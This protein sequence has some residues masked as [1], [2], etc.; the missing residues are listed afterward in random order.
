MHSENEQGASSEKSKKLMVTKKTN[1]FDLQYPG[2][3]SENEILRNKDGI[4]PIVLKQDRVWL[5]PQNSH[6]EN[7][8]NLIVFGDNLQFLKTVYENKDALIKDRI[9]GRVKLIYID[10]PFATGEHYRANQGQTAYS[11]KRVGAD[12]IEFLRR[13]LI[14]AREIL[15]DDGVIVVRN[16]YNYGHYVKIILDEIFSLEN[17]INE[18]IINRKRK[19]MGSLK[20][21][22]VA[23]EYLYAY[24]KS[25]RYFFENQWAKKPLSKIKW[26]SFLSQ[27]ERNPP[28]RQVLGLTFLPPAGQH[29]SLNQQ[30]TTRL[31]KEHY[32][33]V[34]HKP[35]GAIFYYSE[36]G[37]DDRFYKVIST[38]GVNKFKYQDITNETEVYGVRD[39]REIG[40]FRQAPVDEF[41]IEY[42]TREEEKITSDWRDIPSYTDTTGYPTENSEPLLA[43]IIKSFTQP[44]DLVLDFFA[45]SGTTAIVAE[46]LNRRWIAVDMGKLAYS[47]IQKRLLQIQHSKNLE[48]K[49]KTHAKCASTFLT[50]ATHPGQILKNHE[51]SQYKKLISTVF[52]LKEADGEFSEVAFDGYLADRPVLIPEFQQLTIEAI[53]LTYLAKLARQINPAHDLQVYVIA[54]Q[55]AFAFQQDLLRIDRI[56]FYFLR[57]PDTIL[58]HLEDLI[59]RQQQ[60]TGKSKKNHDLEEAIG[61]QLIKP[62]LVKAWLKHDEAEYVLVIEK[63]QTREET[64]KLKRPV[65]GFAGLDSIFVDRHYNGNFFRYDL[66]FFNHQLFPFAHQ[67]PKNR[68]EIHQRFQEINAQGLE[69]KLGEI[70][71]NEK[72]MVIYTD[73]FGNFF[74]EVFQIKGA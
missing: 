45:G 49:N 12:F 56:T 67:R 24:S 20:K 60:Q 1:E 47:T 62:P 23:Y 10:P 52:K 3:C 27:E 59:Q 2:K 58:T 39:I 22:E 63:F 11:A 26:T 50:L 21:Y 32:L 70:A 53:D 72:I 44:G 43:R 35:S 16:A 66:N 48:K 31:L 65:Q 17:F 42:L 54:P 64:G 9:K 41:K 4:L 28:Q 73:I 18:F 25:E 19:S 68:M 14:L 8:Q 69:L 71:A 55:W 6:N 61:F 57:L 38:K 51:Q 5:N 36:S 33:R 29:F 7:W 34:R 30:K 13:R 40:K 46:K 15:A 37:N 74:Q